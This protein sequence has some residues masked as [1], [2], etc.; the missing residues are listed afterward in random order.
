M[1]VVCADK[2]SVVVPTRRG[3]LVGVAASFLCAPAIV[4]VG[5][6]MPVRRVVIA[7]RFSA[8]FVERL[9]YDMCAS[10]LL[11]DPRKF[12][13]R[14]WT[15]SEAERSEAERAV[16]YAL[17]HGFLSRQREEEMQL[18]FANG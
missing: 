12:N 5:S 2:R 13:G 18:F 17:K 8:G 16:R 6:I 1:S 15:L 7:E 9:R 3:V 11:H 4:R 10:H 14:T